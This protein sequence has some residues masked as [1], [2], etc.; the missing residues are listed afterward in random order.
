MM[1]LQL[2]IV[3]ISA[4]W[5]HVSGL[6][7]IKPS[8]LIS[9][10]PFSN[11][12]KSRFSVI[13]SVAAV[14][15][16]I[17]MDFDDEDDDYVEDNR[18]F[19][20]F[21]ESFMKIQSCKKCRVNV[22]DQAQALFDE[23]YEAYIM[24]EDPSLWPNTTIYNILLDTYAWSQ[25]KDGAEKAQHILDR[26]EDM[27][28]ESIARPNVLSYMHVMDAWANRNAPIQAEAI[29]KRMQS[30]FDLTHNQDIYPDTKAFNKL[31]GAWMKSDK[32]DNAEKAEMILQSM[33]DDYET[34]G[35]QRVIPNQKSFV[36]VMRC[37]GKLKTDSGLQ[38]VREL[39][40]TISRLYRVTG[41][42]ELQ[43]DTQIYNELINAIAQNKEMSDHSQQAESV[44]YE[45][46]EAVKM[47]HDV[48]QPNAATFRHVIYGYKGVTDAGVAFKIEKLLELARN[49]G[50]EINASLYNSAIQVIAWTRDVEKGAL[51]WK[52]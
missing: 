32:I 20:D 17:I 15:E 44:L 14:N 48:L 42:A 18:T 21:Y 10:L 31:I 16:E 7:P 43:P 6:I 11:S 51:C 50:V 19:N 24:S 4:S 23:M 45:M 35:N 3:L 1:P 34:N 26:M 9:N 22:G 8:M 36:N 27:T 38:K 12:L 29:M 40:D 39:F 25:A 33:I 28:V 30:R 47:G 2:F 5:G 52:L 37:Y 46:L 41:N 13:F 49:S